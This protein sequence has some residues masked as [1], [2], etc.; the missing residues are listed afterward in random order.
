LA[1]RS[2]EKGRERAE[3]LDRPGNT[4][5]SW[6]QI[7]KVVSGLAGATTGS[8]QKNLV[9]DLASDGKRFRAHDAMYEDSR[10]YSSS[11]QCQRI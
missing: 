8:E 6:H 3:Q 7:N 9:N 10:L 11:I 2:L 4:G 5:Q 1:G